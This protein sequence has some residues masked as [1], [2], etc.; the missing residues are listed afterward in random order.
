MFTEKRMCRQ[1]K[2]GSQQEKK[3]K[4]SHEG[5]QRYTNCNKDFHYLKSTCAQGKLHLVCILCQSPIWT[6][7]VH[8]EVVITSTKIKCSGIWGER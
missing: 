6:L 2:S 1:L 3:Y 5:S 7:R 8:A 4:I